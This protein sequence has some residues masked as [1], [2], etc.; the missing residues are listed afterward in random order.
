MLI[1][2]LFCSTPAK[3]LWEK[4][5]MKEGDRGLQDEIWILPSNQPHYKG[6]KKNV[7]DSIYRSP[8]ESLSILYIT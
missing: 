5:G 2:S 8:I 6:K 7:Q 4:D 1:L 3:V